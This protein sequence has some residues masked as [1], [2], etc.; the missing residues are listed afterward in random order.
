MSRQNGDIR[1]N[2]Q[3][4]VAVLLAM[5]LPLLLLF[6]ALAV[7]IGFAY[8]T[9]A[10][11][12]K[13]VD[14]ACLTA[15]KNLSQG[16]TT[17]R[18]LALSSFTANYGTSGLDTNSPV[19][20]VSF[21]TNTAGQ[22]LVGVTATA[23]I[24]TFFMRL[25]PQFQTISVANTAQATRG[26]LIMTVVLDRSGSMTSNGG[27]TALPP[28]VTMFV[29]LFDNAADE[30]A[31]TSFASNATTDVAIN[32]NFKTPVTNATNAM[33]Y[34]GGTFGPGGLTLAQ[35]QNDSVTIL[36]GQNVV[37]VTLYFT[38][39]YVNTIQ[40]T[41][42][43]N[44]V[45]TLYNFGGFDS[46]NQIVF[47]N[48]TTGNGIYYYDGSSTW[49]TC[50]DSSCGSKTKTTTACLKNVTGF[51]SAIDGKTKAF[52]QP[53]VTA[54]A[55]YRALQTAT[56]MR[57]ETVGTYVYAIGLGSKIDKPFLQKLAN[58][59]ASSTYDPTQPIGIADFV[60]NCPSTQCS[61]E[62]QAVF[63]TIAARILLRLTQ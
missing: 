18:T 57:T 3:V 19:V 8:V 46:G 23:T 4:Q 31:M 48:P 11:L 63:Q 39:G 27:S 7:D 5:C 44:G 47:F 10:R 9:K 1:M 14:A 53:N 37:K 2:E 50:S 52:N 42:S 58:D 36:P 41:L 56:S 29:N 54:D 26:K 49:Y 43:C 51:V 32:Y 34:G 21:T 30:V 16:Q 20:N 13:S 33:S 61:S 12:S 55:Q 40:N 38:D 17:A 25:L 22:T 45:P 62:L 6:S 24:R 60:T 59:P 15:M 28:A 35:T